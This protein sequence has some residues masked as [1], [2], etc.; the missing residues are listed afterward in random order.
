MQETTSAEDKQPIRDIS[1]AL[2]G[3]PRHL[4]VGLLV[5]CNI[6]EMLNWNRSQSR[7]ARN[8][9]NL[10]PYLGIESQNPFRA[11]NA[12]FVFNYTCYL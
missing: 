1:C 12:I 4:V 11:S 8:A 3:S 2:T 7:Y 9:L 6:K 5:G 10:C